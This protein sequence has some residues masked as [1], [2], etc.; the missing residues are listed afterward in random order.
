VHRLAIWIYRATGAGIAIA[1]MDVLAGF[2]D[3]PVA[4]VPF[5]TSI[6][7]TLALPDSEGA[8]PYAVI[9][10]H[11]LS[12]S[13]GFVALWCLGPGIIGSAAGVGLATLLMIAARATHPPAGIDGFLVPT[14]ALPPIW[15]LKPVLA[16]AVLI[17]V[18]ARL[19][20]K[21]EKWFLRPQETRT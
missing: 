9:A 18:F 10:G 14:L 1:V 16:G 2:V 3:E 19:W 5:V 12:T 8:R 17:A 20:A 21:G 11:L 6:V 4:R 7:L 15:A 13:A